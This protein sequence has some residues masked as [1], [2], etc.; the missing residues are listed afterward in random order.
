[1]EVPQAPEGKPQAKKGSR[2]GDLHYVRA[3]RQ[4]E[5]QK[6]YMKETNSTRS[7]EQKTYPYPPQHYDP[8]PQTHGN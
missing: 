7:Q 5:V 8:V 6:V 3:L 4:A 1:M 2:F